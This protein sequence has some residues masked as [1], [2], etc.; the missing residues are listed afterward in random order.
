M[1]DRQPD[2]SSE[3]LRGWQERGDRAALEELLWIEIGVLKNRLRRQGSRAA[4]ASISVSD[5]AQEV[6][7]R[8]LE[9]E[10]APR[11]DHPHALRSY[12]WTA[13]RRLLAEHLRR[14][15]SATRQLEGSRAD[16]LDQA[17]QTS[18][19]L[20]GVES[21]DRADALSVALQL[22]EPEDRELLELYYYRSVDAAGI[23]QALGI[24]PDAARTRVARARTS[25]ARKL[26]KWTEWIG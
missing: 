21:A 7:I 5:V 20:E 24:S 6:V 9:V 8:A 3:L 17:L 25:L 18:G 26:V 2:R 23:A 13:A 10:P 11:F 1:L 14:G 16:P 4:D 15:K 19:G 12:L 22:L